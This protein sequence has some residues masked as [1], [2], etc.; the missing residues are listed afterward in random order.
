ML[1]GPML[2]ADLRAVCYDE[3]GPT[4]RILPHAIVEKSSRAYRQPLTEGS[5]R[6]VAHTVRHAG[7][8]GVISMN[9]AGRRL[10]RMRGGSRPK[11]EGFFPHDL[12]IPEDLPR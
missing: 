7:V 9:C 10:R 12:L 1:P 5:T 11:R 8:T 6:A 2:P 4:S 3:I